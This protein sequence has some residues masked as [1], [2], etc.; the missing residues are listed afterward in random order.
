MPRRFSVRR[1]PVHG[2]GVF[3]LVA[4]PAGELLGPYGGEL[5][6]AATADERFAASGTHG[7]TFFFG[8]SGGKVIDGGSAGNSMRW[9]NHSCDPNCQALEYEDEDVVVIETLRDVAPGE[10]LFI[11]YRLQVDE[12]DPD[13]AEFACACDAPTCRTVMLG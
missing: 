10:E 6:D 8:L 12:E 4:M 13:T 2:R 7:H 1:S 5:I 11:D 3:A 9:L